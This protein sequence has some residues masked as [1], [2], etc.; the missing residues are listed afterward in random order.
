DRLAIAQGGG[1]VCPTGFH[2]TVKSQFVRGLE[3]R[4]R[5]TIGVEAQQV[6]AKRFGGAHDALP[7]LDIGGR[8]AGLRKD[9]ALQGAAKKE[10]ASVEIKLRARALKAAQTDPP[11]AAVTVTQSRR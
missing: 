9:A 6:Q 1:G 8:M 4:F 7:S 2:L 3:C 5:G 10:L 11:R